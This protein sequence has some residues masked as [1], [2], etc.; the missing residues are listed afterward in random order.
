[1]AG[2]PWTESELATVRAE[3]GTTPAR[4]LAARL[5]RSPR[6]VYQAADRMGLAHQ[7]R[8][9]VTLTWEAEL[10]RLH[11]LGHCD[12][13]IAARLGCERHTASKHRRRLGL[14]GHARGERTRAKVRAT[15]AE[16]CRR[17]GVANLGALRSLVFARR[18][19]EAGWPAGLRPREVDIL[20]ALAIRG[21]LTRREIAGAVG[22][23]WLGSRKSLKCRGGRGSYLADLIAAGLVVSLGRV[24]SGRGKGGS[25]QLYSLALDLERRA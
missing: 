17:A 20:D 7:H 25:S 2:R 15:T 24:V 8:T 5:G 23:R 14:V 13:D 3:Y 6:A 18:S 16:Q 12:T 21:P 11:A 10:R 19:A 4:E 1:M 22:M 9:D